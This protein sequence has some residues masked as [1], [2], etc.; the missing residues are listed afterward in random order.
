MNTTVEKPGRQGGSTPPIP[1]RGGIRAHSK[2]GSFGASWWARDWV[3]SMT[4]AQNL[5]TQSQLRR[6]RQYARQ[7]Q[8]LALDIGPGTIRSQVQ[9]SRPTPHETVISVPVF[10]REELDAITSIL[11]GSIVYAAKL[12]N[13]EILSELNDDFRN[14]GI[15]L[16][17]RLGSGLSAE[18]SCGEVENPCR[19]AVATHLLVAEEMDRDPALLLKLRGLPLDQILDMALGCIDDAN[20]EC[21][22]S[23]A[24]LP[25]P[26][27][28]PQPG[29]ELDPAEFWSL[30]RE[31]A[32]CRFMAEAEPVVPPLH[33]AL[34]ARKLGNFPFWR[35]GEDFT[36][37]LEES[38]SRASARAMDLFVGQPQD[39]E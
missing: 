31:E 3:S 13:R 34:P 24:D 12:L 8:V 11:S 32:H 5:L 25:S 38:Y 23:G 22:N 26:C 27:S 20:I 17:P 29:K 28:F 10:S 14:A 7:G 2:Q 35:S 39:E 16:F 6:G 30:H 1:G 36:K 15:E 19:H 21:A 9:G 33:H 37:F 4:D 18:C